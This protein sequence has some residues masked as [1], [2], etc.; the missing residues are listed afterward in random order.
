MGSE[1]YRDFEHTGPET[2][3]GRYMRTFWQPVYRADDLKS[4]HAVPLLIMSE[5]FTLFRGESGTPYWLPSSWVRE[6]M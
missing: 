1:I 3:A 2:L 4:G 6:D 5:S